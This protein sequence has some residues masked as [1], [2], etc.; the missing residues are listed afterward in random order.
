[1]KY[2]L[3]FCTPIAIILACGYCKVNYTAWD[4]K[5]TKHTDWI[6]K[7]FD[8]HLWNYLQYHFHA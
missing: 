2:M 3:I 6:E 1:M 7:F 5:N 4:I 8:D